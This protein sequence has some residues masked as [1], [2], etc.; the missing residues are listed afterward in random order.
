MP[1]PSG[2]VGDDPDDVGTGRLGEDHH[3]EIGQV[4]DAQ[5]DVG[6]VEGRRR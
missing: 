3:R 6:R 4:A 5:V 1:R 2:R